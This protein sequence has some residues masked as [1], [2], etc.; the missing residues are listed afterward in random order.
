ME[1][2]DMV[3]NEPL[4]YIVQPKLDRVVAYMQRTFQSR[5]AVGQRTRSEELA[6]KNLDQQQEKQFQQMSLEEQLSFLANLPAHLSNIKCKLISTNGERE[7]IIRQYDGMEIVMDTAF[8]EAVIPRKEVVS[9]ALIGLLEEG[10]E[11]RR[12]RY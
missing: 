9:L 5:A 6:E 7:G 4:L 1:R 12:D 10:E 3:E 11:E 2:R 8:G